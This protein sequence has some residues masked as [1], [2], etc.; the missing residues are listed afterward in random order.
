MEGKKSKVDVIVEKR[1]EQRKLLAKKKKNQY[2]KEYMRSWQRNKRAKEKEEREYLDRKK[3]ETERKQEHINILKDNGFNEVEANEEFN[4]ILI[5][6]QKELKKT[7]RK[8]IKIRIKKLNKKDDFN[9][10]LDNYVESPKGLMAVKQDIINRIFFAKQAVAYHTPAELELK[11]ENSDDKRY[12]LSLESLKYS[13]LHRFSNHDTTPIEIEKHDCSFVYV[14]NAKFKGRKT[15]VYYVKLAEN[16]D[17]KIFNKFFDLKK[18]HSNLVLIPYEYRRGLFDFDN[19]DTESGI[20]K[21]NTFLSKKRKIY[22]FD[23]GLILNPIDIRIINKNG[24]LNCEFWYFNK[25]IY[26]FSFTN[27]KNVI[28][29]IENI[30]PKINKMPFN[31]FEP[32]LMDGVDVGIMKNNGHIE[33]NLRSFLKI[34]KKEPWLISIVPNFNFAFFKDGE[35]NHQ[36][37][38]RLAISWFDNFKRNIFASVD[39]LSVESM[40]LQEEKLKEFI[41]SGVLYVGDLFSEDIDDVIVFWKNNRL[42]EEQIRFFSL[43]NCTKY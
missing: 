37:R 23:K 2:L 29:Q 34:N 1:K 9:C 26:V 35:A 19:L 40:K 21:L 30:L 4:K 14:G 6:R 7:E 5:K 10:E 16:I 8:S 41:D 22:Q 3:R 31:I 42:R 11:V 24:K 27:Y 33:G 32:D 13:T 28:T 12:E 25:K 17:P 36:E 15:S 43:F 20:A 39:N 38:R 18:C